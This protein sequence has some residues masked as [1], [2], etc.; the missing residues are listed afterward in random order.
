[1]D[2]ISKSQQ[3]HAVNQPSQAMPPQKSGSKAWA[4]VLGLLA[5]AALVLVAWWLYV[6]GSGLKTE[7]QEST[8]QTQTTQPTDP[9]STIESDIDQT[10]TVIDQ[11]LKQIDE[12]I[13][14]NDDQ[15][16]DI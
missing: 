14:S 2:D 8:D 16:P 7:T 11:E 4:W 3:T 10:L 15:T 13:E 5:V 1:M 9:V 6:Y 12:D